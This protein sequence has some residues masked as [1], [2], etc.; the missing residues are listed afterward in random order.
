MSRVELFSEICLNIK[1]KKSCCA[2]VS[3]EEVGSSAI[4]NDGFPINALATATLCC[5]PTLKLLALYWAISSGNRN[6]LK[7]PM[8][9]L[10]YLQ[11]FLTLLERNTKEVKHYQRH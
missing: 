5:C 10:F 3:S 4:I 1:S 7:T 2:F 6:C 9:P 11:Y 8:L